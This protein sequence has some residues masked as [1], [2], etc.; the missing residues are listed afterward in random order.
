MKEAQSP[1]NKKKVIRT[2]ALSGSLY[3]LLEDQ[4][5]FL[6]QY[7]DILAIGSD[8]DNYFIERLKQREGVRSKEI[9]IERKIS[10]VKDLVSL[11]RLY[12]LFRK[13]KP[14]MVHSITPKAGLLTMIAGYF[15]R[16]PARVH[17]FTGLIFP[18]QTGMMKT[19]LIFFDKLI[20]RF[21]TNLYPEGNGVKNDLLAYKIT[22]KPL[23]VIA[24]GN[25]NGIDLVKFNKTLFTT[26]ENQL[27]RKKIGVSE[28]DVVLLYIG[29]LVND[30]GV[31]ELAQAFTKI[32]A[33]HNHVK[34][35]MVGSDKGETD[36]LPEDT[37]NIINTNDAI[38]YVGHQND[39]RPYLAMSDIFVFPS[40][41]EGFPNV[42]LEAGAMGLPAIVTDINGSNEI[43]ENNINGIIIPSKDT[44]ALLNAMQL[45][46][47]NPE[48]LIKLSKCARDKIT[49][50]FD[51]NFVWTEI[52]DEYRLIERN[53][54]KNNI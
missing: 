39:V 53:L 40:Y 41:R 16:V 48:F 21:A 44:Q 12:I 7:Y 3:V 37:W 5:R 47:K 10:I 17:T 8:S 30:K 22:K 27:L 46:I 52:L 24:N 6:N 31:N 1:K 19:I 26:T 25:V 45:C 18:T 9:N 50:R 49:S 35:V 51:R 38:H 28:K 43:I 29:R 32:S 15:A 42:V 2:A 13:E 4:L 11:Y 20:C 14:F 34:L 36:L 33:S 54:S 23:K